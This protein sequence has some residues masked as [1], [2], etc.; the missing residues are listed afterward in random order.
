VA[1][2]VGVDVGGTKVLAGLVTEDGRILATERVATPSEDAAGAVDAVVAAVRAVLDGHVPDGESVEAVGLGAPGFIAPDRSTVLFAPNMNWR[3]HPVGE[4]VTKELG[5]P[6]VVENDA[7]A[8]AWAEYRFG[9]GHNLGSA[10]DSMALVT[11]GTGIGS[12]FV[13]HGSVLRGAHG[14]AGEFGHVTLVPDGRLCGCGGRGCIEQY[15]SGRALVRAARDGAAGHPEQAAHLLAVAG[16]TVEDIEGPEV[17]QAARDGDPVAV[18]AFA[19]TGRW[20]GI[21]L[22]DLVWALDPACLVVGGGVV[23]AGE[24]LLGPVRESCQD[25]LAARGRWEYAEIRPAAMGNEAGLVGA[26]DLARSR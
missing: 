16:G 13:L 18:A 2:T 15:C 22:A 14:I 20:L 1:L 7:N 17:T 10:A 26:A 4:Q 11:V 8:A 9:A 21:A 6:A 24:L 12:G 25:A 19:A 5:L 3:D 23:A